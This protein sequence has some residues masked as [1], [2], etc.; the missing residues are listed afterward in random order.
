VGAD[1]P[2]R[3]YHIAFEADWKAGL[4]AGVYRVSTRGATLDE[5]GFIHAS[6]EHQVAPVAELFYSDVTE[7]LVVLVIDTARLDGPV[8]VERV[9]DG[10]ERFPHIYGELP[11]S[12]VVEVRTLRK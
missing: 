7:P 11:T 6:L 9:E 10:E 1:A 2:R 12:A 8:V 5:V 4:E 3:I